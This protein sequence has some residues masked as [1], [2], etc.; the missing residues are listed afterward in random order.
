MPLLLIAPVA[1]EPASNLAM[2]TLLEPSESSLGWMAG[3]R[4]E[5]SR[6]SDGM[7]KKLPP[8]LLCHSEGSFLTRA[9]LPHMFLNETTTCG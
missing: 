6:R 3:N 5:S 2:V 8:Y 9:P 7:H 4:E 1:W